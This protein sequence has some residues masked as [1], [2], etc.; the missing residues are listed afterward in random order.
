[1]ED[2]DIARS[3]FRL[4]EFYQFVD[5]RTDERLNVNVGARV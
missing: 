3:F 2:R 4:A 5:A 1:M